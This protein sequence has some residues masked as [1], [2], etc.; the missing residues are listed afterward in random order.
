[1]A[2]FRGTVQGNRG[3][4]SRLGHGGLTVTANGWESGIKVVS[5]ISIASD[6][7]PTDSDIHAV[8]MTT[9]SSSQKMK[10]LLGHVIVDSDSNVRW[11]PAFPQNADVVLKVDS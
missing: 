10:I 8:W 9:G 1:M 4:Q 6:I 3:E 2:R 5:C 11:R 7:A